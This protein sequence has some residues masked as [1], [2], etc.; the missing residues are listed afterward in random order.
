MKFKAALG[1]EH[2][3]DRVIVSG[4][5]PLDITWKGGVQGDVATSAIVVN[6][7][8]SLLRAAPGLHTM[9][10]IPLVSCTPGAVT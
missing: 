1:L 5:P 8:A 6:S 3:H 4:E 2:P 9:A 7:I 10:S